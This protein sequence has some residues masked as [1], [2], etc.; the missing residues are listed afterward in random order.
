MKG[1]GDPYGLKKVTNGMMEIIWEKNLDFSIREVIGKTLEVFGHYSPESEDKIMDFILQRV[2]NLFAGKDISPG[3]RKA[4]MS[5]NEENFVIQKEKIDALENFF[6]TGSAKNLLVP[7]IRIANILKQ[8]YEKN[9]AF[10]DFEES[11][12]MDETEKQLFSFFIKKI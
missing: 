6:K 1:S 10:G 8:A 3:I 7:F 4:V 9:I 12:L 5:V 2:D 11:L